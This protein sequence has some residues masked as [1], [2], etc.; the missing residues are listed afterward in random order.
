MFQME[1]EMEQA[2]RKKVRTRFARSVT[3][4]TPDDERRMSD[5]Y[6]SDGESSDLSVRAEEIANSVLEEEEGKLVG[7]WV[8]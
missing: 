1:Q 4:E 7:R 2:K 6:Q 5:G 8:G 3:P